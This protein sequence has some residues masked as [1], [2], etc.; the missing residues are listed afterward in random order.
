MKPLKDFLSILSLKGSKNNNQKWLT[1]CT[2]WKKLLNEP[3]DPSCLCSILLLLSALELAEMNK[4]C[5]LCSPNI[6]TPIIAKKWK[7]RLDA[8]SMPQTRWEMGKKICLH[9][10]RQCLLAHCMYLSRYEIRSY[11]LFF[12]VLPPQYGNMQSHVWLGISCHTLPT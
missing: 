4:S 5:F 7:K 3:S 1:T 8:T 12:V 9:T 2:T 11:S 6:T 10:D